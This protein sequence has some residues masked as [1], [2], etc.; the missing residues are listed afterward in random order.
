ME[1]EHLIFAVPRKGSYVSELS[2][3]DLREVSQARKIIECNSIDLLKA[4][5]VRVLPNVDLALTSASR[6]SVPFDDNPEEMVRYLR[7]FVDYHI[8]LVESARS[9]KQ[10]ENILGLIKRGDYEQA[11][12]LLRSHIDSLVTILENRAEKNSIST[13]SEAI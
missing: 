6:F 7:A 8:K 9:R 12:Y 2:I 4:K 11:K 10:H 1:K 3:Q 13:T 5:N